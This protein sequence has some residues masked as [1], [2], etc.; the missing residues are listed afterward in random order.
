MPTPQFSSTSPSHRI[1]KY[2]M[3][4][5]NLRWMFLLQ[6]GHSPRRRL[7]N[8]GG[9]S[10]HNHVVSQNSE[11]QLSLGS[12]VVLLYN[13]TTQAP[14]WAICMSQE[15]WMTMSK[16]Q[17]YCTAELAK[18]HLLTQGRLKILFI[19]DPRFVKLKQVF[20]LWMWVFKSTLFVLA[21]SCLTFSTCHLLPCLFLKLLYLFKIITIGIL[22]HQI[23][24]N[25][26]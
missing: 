15:F 2:L 22:L 11:W 21:F 14:L 18:L 20:I 8:G 1:C 17:T 23:F 12:S 7:V 6:H 3:P 25:G 5:F 10:S 4:W 9:R 19:A 13:S 24:V 26:R 16:R